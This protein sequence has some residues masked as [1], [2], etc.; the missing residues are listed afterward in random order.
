M[1]EISIEE[2]K[3]PWMSIDNMK[4]LWGLDF[5]DPKLYKVVQD[6]HSRFSRN[7]KLL[8]EE[9]KINRILVEDIL[10]KQRLTSKKREA[11]SLSMS[12]SQFEEVI[13]NFDEKYGYNTIEFPGHSS[14]V[15]TGKFIKYFSKVRNNGVYYDYERKILFEQIEKEFNI[16]VLPVY[17]AYYQE[18]LYDKNTYAIHYCAKTDKPICLSHLVI[19]ETKR[20]AYMGFDYELDTV[21]GHYHGS[22]RD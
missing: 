11:I 20:P 3:N 5:S 8:N 15:Y 13:R 19:A 1:N 14:L 10:Q 6:L 22:A 7:V 2:L 9:L 4:K 12:E 21:P 17:C 16:K 18:D